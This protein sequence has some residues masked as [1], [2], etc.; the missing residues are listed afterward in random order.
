M[1]EISTPYQLSVDIC[2]CYA[3]YKCWI[4]TCTE[5]YLFSILL[6]YC[7]CA[8]V[9]HR[10]GQFKRE[11]NQGMSV[12]HKFRLTLGDNSLKRIF[13]KC[14][15]NL[16]INQ[17]ARLCA[18]RRLS[19]DPGS[20]ETEIAA[21]LL[22]VHIDTHI[23]D[24]SLFMFFNISDDEQSSIHQEGV[25]YLGLFTAGCRQLLSLYAESY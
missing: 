18:C 1:H 14:A 15:V 24:P 22:Y 16:Q 19:S 3:I 5:Y 9:K 12:K 20:V 23:H 2:E 10:H 13:S 25:I 11:Q 4:F 6:R 21:L 7:V 17:S 8:C